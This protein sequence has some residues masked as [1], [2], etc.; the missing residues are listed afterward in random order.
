MIKISAFGEILIRL[1]SNNKSVFSSL[2]DNL[3][4]SIG[5]SELNFLINF[6]NLGGKCYFITALPDNPLGKAGLAV[7]DKFRINRKYSKI[8]KKGRMGLYFIE[9]GIANRSSVITYD[10]H[11]SSI[12]F[13][14]F[15]DFSFN[16]VFFKTTHYHI[17]GTSP[18]LSKNML[19][20]TIQSIRL[21][22][23]MGL[24][25]SFDLNYRSKLWNYKIN[26]VKVNKVKAMSDILMS[27]DYLFGNETDIQ[28]FFKIDFRKKNNLS[29]KHNLIYYQ[30]LLLSVSKMFPHIKII[31][32]YI[33]NTKNATNNHISGVCYT[34][35]TN[36]FFFSPNIMNDYKPY[37]VEP[38]LDRIGIGDSFSSAFIFGLHKFNQIQL[39]LDFAVCSSA[40]KHTYRG[41]FNYASFD[42]VMALMNGD[43]F[44][45]IKK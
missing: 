9:E 33:R 32:L 19:N 24:E 1:V 10:R 40:L 37:I 12:N 35:Q 34:R 43:K 30:N 23:E 38:V 6:S 4:F 41:D 5:G 21:A 31:A 29:G 8:T 22:K 17:T 3:E 18:G 28:N 44:R 42:E 36:Q 16:R 20:T 25:V 13:F 11:D 2:P 15:P 26:G 45:K 39:A 14:D 7:L 27:C